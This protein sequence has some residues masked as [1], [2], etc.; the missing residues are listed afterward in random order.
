MGA[1]GRNAWAK[2]LAY[3][4]DYRRF[5]Y[6]A[7]VAG[8]A[9]GFVDLLVPLYGNALGVSNLTIGLLFAVFSLPK[10]IISPIVG[11]LSDYMGSRRTIVAVGF[12]LAGVLYTAVPILGFV[13]AFLAIRFLLGGVDAAIRPTAQ[14]LI[15]E[16]GGESGRG[17]SFGIYSSFRTLGTVLGPAVV[18][19]LIAV[20]GFA[21]SFAITGVLFGIAGVLT[22]L[23]ISRDFGPATEGLTL[24][25][26]IASIRDSFGGATLQVPSAT[27]VLLY[28]IV[29]LR[30]MGLHAYVRFLPLYLESV[31]FTTAVVGTLFSVRTLSAAIF[32]PLGGRAS[33]RLGR[34]TILGVGVFLSGVTPLVLYL[35]PTLPWV[36]AGLFVGGVGRALFIPTLP[37]YLSDISEQTTRGSLIGKTSA[38]SSLAVG[39]API[40]AGAIGDVLAIADILVFSGVALGLGVVLFGPLGLLAK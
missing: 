26:A 8:T 32:F 18:G 6:V 2:W 3:P 34:L 20:S 28:A 4:E 35:R 37:A 14:T 24:R 21:V 33:D 25:E 9:Y 40:V 22:Y 15:S 30:F 13:T 10:A 16:V 7:F 12:V 27:L 11:V 5:C 1:V 38:V 31:G 39:V 17:Q 36:V 19:V 23:L 29:F